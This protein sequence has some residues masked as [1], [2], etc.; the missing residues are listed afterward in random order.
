MRIDAHQHFWH[1]DPSMTWISDEM[2][3]VRK[4]FTPSDLAPL[5]KAHQIDGCI[6]VQVNQTPQENEYMLKFADQYTFIKGVVGWVDLC[7]PLLEKELEKLSEQKLMKGFRHILQAEPDEQFM[8]RKNFI[9]GI[10]RLQKFNFTY[11]L[12]IKPQ[13]LSHALK[14]IRQF[15]EQ[16]FVIDHIAKPDIANGHYKDWAIGMKAL[17]ACENVWCKFSGMVTEA[18]WK[19]WTQHDILPYMNLVLEVF[20][21]A[22]LMYGSDWPVCLVAASYERT[23]GLVE[24]FIQQLSL[25][26]QNQIMGETAARFY[27]TLEK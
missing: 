4:N 20:G 21:P 2:L 10:S 5:L 25:S 1:Y 17:S 3:T 6:S 11:D 13:H 9:Q 23:I 16:K 22:R 7:N 8:L 18:N 14:L 15:P 26:E 12:L 27:S 19:E 24:E